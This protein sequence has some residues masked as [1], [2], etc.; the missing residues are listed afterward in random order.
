[1]N[2]HVP[3][4]YYYMKTLRRKK[5]M[6]L[7]VLSF[8]MIVISSTT[9]G[10]AL[11]DTHNNHKKKKNVR[12]DASTFDQISKCGGSWTIQQQQQQ[13]QHLSAS[14][15]NSFNSP[16]EKWRRHTHVPKFLLPLMNGVFG[17]RNKSSGSSWKTTN[18][19][20]KLYYA[21]KNNN[22][23]NNTVS[24]HI[25]PPPREKPIETSL[26]TTNK[27]SFSVFR[28][29]EMSL[30][31]VYLC[32]IFAITLP[33]VLLPVVAAEQA[34]HPSLIPATVAAIAA[35]STLGG[36]IG[37]C[38][39]GFVCQQAGGRQSSFRYIL[40]MACGCLLLSF[41]ATPQYL[42][43]ALCGIEYCS[44]MQWVA[45]SVILAN[46]Y[47]K[48]PTKFAGGI[49][50][51]S[52]AST[53]G[54]IAAKLL[55]TLLLQLNFSWRWVARL[56]SAMCVLGA[57]I[58]YGTVREYPPGKPIPPKPKLEV[59]EIVSS[60]KHVTG[61]PLFWQVGIAHGFTFLV[62]SSERVLG[63]FF[64]DAIFLPRH[65]CGGLTT[66]VTLGFMHGIISGRA[67]DSLDIVADKTKF[68]TKRYTLA[69]LSALGLAFLSNKSIISGLT[70]FASWLPAALA[71]LVS[72]YM[73]SSAAF[74]F[75]QLPALASKS[76][77][78]NQ[79]VA[80]S[81]VDALGFI[82]ST[83]FW[84]SVGKIVSHPVLGSHG[85]SIVWTLLAAM[86]AFAGG[87]MLPAITPILHKEAELKVGIA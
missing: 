18:K 8:W 27:S 30:M 32:S 21:G 35:T 66:S 52:L 48:E 42:A 9:A 43:W 60:V 40:G 25:T 70:Q 46:H 2:H 87:S 16:I 28:N 67:F 79:A 55:G 33:V 26:T 20:S 65:L 12:F 1:M 57:T 72:G 47:E 54:T 29:L 84:G 63:V 4:S 78:Q 34:A 58:M 11:K 85:W 17:S 83:F 5:S 51:L 19:S 14:R 77:K 56:G 81:Y 71:A 82:F 44:S 13:Q 59:Q 62:R 45:M 38:V 73:A 3:S 36:A 49:A 10:F 39:N 23:N 15:S 37:K 31:C 74:Q 61:S 7:V 75:Y 69:V 86:L 80:V 6:L 50:F 68:I 53:S 41:S 24:L 22:N 76:F 64:H